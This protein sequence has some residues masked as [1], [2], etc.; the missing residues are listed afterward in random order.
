MKLANFVLY[1]FSKIEVCNLKIREVINMV[2]KFFCENPNID[3]KL[4]EL[5]VTLLNKIFDLIEYIF[6]R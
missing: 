4:K 5:L 2:D 1:L 3:Y 6:S